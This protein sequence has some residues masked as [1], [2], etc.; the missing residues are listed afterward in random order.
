MK[1]V[2]SFVLA[3]MTLL[4]G[5]A[6]TSCTDYQDEI[7]A[8]D[9]RVT[10]VESLVSQTNK[11]IS[12]LQKVVTAWANGWYIENMAYLPIEEGSGYVINFRKDFFDV[13]TGDSVPGKTQRMAAIVH[14]GEKGDHVDEYGK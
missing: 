9:N 10:Y 1:T 3:A 2:K 14:D 5:A 12:N 4:A 11:D 13:V 6:A 8:L 7:N